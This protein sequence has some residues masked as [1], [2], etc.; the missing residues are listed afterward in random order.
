MALAPLSRAAWCLAIIVHGCRVAAGAASLIWHFIACLM[1]LLIACLCDCI[2][3]DTKDYHYKH[4]R[5]SWPDVAL[6]TAG[7]EL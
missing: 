1:P 3:E 6:E 5:F 2:R 4:G 7:G